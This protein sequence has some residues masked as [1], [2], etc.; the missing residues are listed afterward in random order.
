MTDTPDSTSQSIVVVVD[1]HDTLPQVLDRIRAAGGVSVTLDIPEHCPI[2]LTATEYRT[3]REAADRSGHTITLRTDDPLRLQ[4]GSMFGL[5]EGT[6]KIYSQDASLDGELA[7]TPSF[8]GWRSAR[9]HHDQRMTQATVEDPISV[10]RRRRTELYEPGVTPETAASQE[11]NAGLSTDAT[12]VALSY[13]DEDPAAGRAWLIGRIVAVVA[14]VA[15]IAGMAGWYFMPAATVE[16]TLRQGQLSTSLLYS[17]TRP[18]ADGP[19][20]AAF[21]VEAVEVAETVPFT[22]SVPATGVEVTPDDSASGSVVLRNASTGAVTVPAGTTLT[23]VTGLSF[24]TDDDVD[25]PAGSPD[26][27]TIG[28]ATVN[29]SAVDPGTGSNLGVGALSGKI[30]DLPVYFSNRD[31]EI[32]GGTD[33][34]VAVV[35]E[36]DIES[37]EAAV[38]SDLRRYVAAGWNELLP[39]GQA[40]LAPSVEAGEPDYTIEQRPGDVS[41]TVTLT[42]TV[43]ATALQF[44]QAA[45]EAQARSHYEDALAAQVPP[46]YEMAPETLVLAEPVLV[47][48]SPDS[49]EYTMGAS[50]TVVAQFDDGA[51][52]AL[53]EDLAG[54][55]TDEADTILANVPAFES[56]SVSRSPGWWPG[57]FPQSSG[58]VTLVVED[59]E[60]V[61]ATPESP[62]PSPVATADADN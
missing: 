41:E 52:D 61:V 24:T 1:E 49:V 62:S 12:H 29:V 32:T 26:G 45:V 5:A 33:R 47:A 21:T 3:L 6:R 31:G 40:I 15:L 16:A 46:G 20:D 23:T 59:A 38:S 50:V 27:S 54:A 4:L 48:E 2:L 30:A 17:V 42:G 13:L 19:P 28:E 51:Q 22:I 10:S 58:R 43:D 55:S 34:E 57:G 39:E 56:W 60:P 9:Q 11:P 25:V 37:L 14:V 36:A 18:G 53:V 8:R 7:E 35:A 44:D